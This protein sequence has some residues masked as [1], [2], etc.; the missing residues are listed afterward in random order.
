[1]LL[2]A[3]KKSRYSPEVMLMP[4]ADAYLLHPAVKMVEVQL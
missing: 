3:G 4:V 1:M 2:P